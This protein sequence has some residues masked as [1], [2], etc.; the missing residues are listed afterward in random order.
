MKTINTGEFTFHNVSINS[1]KEKK[2]QRM[3]ETFTFHNVSINSDFIPKPRER[4]TNLH[5]TMFLL[6]PVT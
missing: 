6:I 5:S 4:F 2:I 3:N 1:R